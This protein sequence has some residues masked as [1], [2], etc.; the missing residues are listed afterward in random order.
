[1]ILRFLIGIP[2]LWIGGFPSQF[3]LLQFVE[4]LLGEAVTQAP[5]QEKSRPIDLFGVWKAATMHFEF[6]GF[7]EEV[8][9]GFVHRRDAGA[10]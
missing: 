3:I 5:S 8:A 4:F 7:M 6:T 10:P 9:L 2:R 1:M